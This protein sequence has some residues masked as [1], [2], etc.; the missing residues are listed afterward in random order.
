MPRSANIAFWTAC[1]M[2]RILPVESQRGYGVGDCEYVILTAVITES[3]HSGNGEGKYCAQ[4]STTTPCLSFLQRRHHRATSIGAAR[5][6][7][8][9]ICKDYVYLTRNAGS[10][11]TLSFLRTRSRGR[12]V[13]F[14]MVTLPRL[15]APC[16]FPVDIVLPANQAHSCRARDPGIYSGGYA[17]RIRRS[18]CTRTPH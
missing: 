1:S 11:H 12:R 10:V 2:C 3:I 7:V 15:H 5:T 9:E 16:P 18:T 17:G 8:L 4:R 6:P 14:I 13:L